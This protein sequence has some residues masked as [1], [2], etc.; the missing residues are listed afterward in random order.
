[1][2]KLT[3]VLSIIGLIG[4]FVGPIIFGIVISPSIDVDML[5]QPV[6]NVTDAYIVIKNVGLEPATNLRITMNPQ[7]DIID[8]KTEFYTEKID[9]DFNGKRSLIGS[10]E[11]LANKQQVVLITTLNSTSENIKFYN[12]YVN[13]DKGST[14]FRLNTEANVVR[15]V[16]GIALFITFSGIFTTLFGIFL[17]QQKKRQKEHQ[18]KIEQKPE[19]T[20]KISR[21]HPGNVL[22]AQ[23]LATIGSV[24]SEKGEYEKALEKLNEAISLD[25]KN[26]LAYNN[27]A[28][29]HSMLGKFDK[30]IDYGTKAIELEPK[31]TSGYHNR[32]TYYLK[33]NKTNEAIDDLKKA[34]EID[35]GYPDAWNTLG[36]ALYYNDEN[37][38]AIEK[39]TKA[40]E[41]D[42]KKFE[43]YNNRGNIFL[44]MEKYTEAIK[45]FKNAL[46]IKEN[47]ISYNLQGVALS[48]LERYDEAIDYFR[49]ATELDPEYG[50][51]HLNWGIA[52]EAKGE[53]EEA[54]EKY[55][56][57][58][59]FL[60]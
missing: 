40:I 45:D 35:P 8:Y 7:F 59:K 47:P 12:I 37:N 4:V 53:K 14:N 2:S 56:I 57:A 9:L 26:F 1:M 28:H 30:A 6:A 41:L 34:L 43:F 22:K 11:R 36:M 33:I 24:F 10:M 60:K 21:P 46:N 17:I 39:V 48:N 16:E 31:N 42:P 23:Q 58:D 15:T 19:E 52:L 18:K 54:F 25:D 55:E 49:K 38:E 44:K 32:A 20:K 27:L 5:L 3:N 50:N 13:H 29:L 51:A